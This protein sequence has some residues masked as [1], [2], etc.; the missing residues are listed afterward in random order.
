MQVI[1]SVR[2]TSTTP[3]A[4]VEVGYV[5]ADIVD[6]A[7]ED[8]VLGQTRRVEVYLAPDVARELAV[9]LLEQS[10]FASRV[11]ADALE[12]LDHSSASQP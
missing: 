6:I 11:K 1:K 7:V 3:H 2:G 10:V 4:K 12:K 5:H 8:T 9:A